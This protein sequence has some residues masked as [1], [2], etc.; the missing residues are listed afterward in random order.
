M[1]HSGSAPSWNTGERSHEQSQTNLSASQLCLSQVYSLASVSSTVN[2]NKRSMCLIGLFWGQNELIHVKHLH[3]CKAVNI[4]LLLLCYFTILKFC[5]KLT[6]FRSSCLT[7]QEAS[8]RQ[9]LWPLIHLSPFSWCCAHTG[10]LINS[11]WTP[12]GKVWVLL[13]RPIKDCLLLL[14]TWNLSQVPLKLS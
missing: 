10:P 14:H 1:Q 9:V 8:R 13:P 7:R 6:H 2:G 12:I 3:V 11:C 5:I 4:L